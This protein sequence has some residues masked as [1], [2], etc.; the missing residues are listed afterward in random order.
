LGCDRRSETP[1]IVH[2]PVSSGVAPK[3]V[4]PDSGG[5]WHSGWRAHPCVIPSRAAAARIADGIC[6]DGKR[7]VVLV[8]RGVGSVMAESSYPA[9]PARLRDADLATRTLPKAEEEIGL[10]GERV[11]L[12]AL[13]RRRRCGPP[14]S[15]WPVPGPAAAPSPLGAPGAGDSP[16]WC[17][18]GRR[19]GMARDPDRGVHWAAWT[20]R[21]RSGDRAH[22]CGWPRGRYS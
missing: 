13:S 22:W 14:A 15:G 8:Q 19:S 11:E 6:R 1:A 4:R 17:G 2:A 5:W 20:S 3:R 12:L 16:R 10:T 18:C 7:V 9:R 21:V